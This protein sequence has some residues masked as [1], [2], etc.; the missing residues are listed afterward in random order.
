MVGVNSGDGRGNLTAYATVF[1]SEAGPAARPRLLGLLAECE[2]RS[3]PSAAAVRRPTRAGSSRTSRPTTSRWIPPIRSA[4][5]TAQQSV[6]TDL[7]NFGP[8]NHYQ[9][10]ERRYSI[11]AMGHYEFGEHADVY[12]QLM[13]NDYESIAQ[14]APG[15]N[16]FN[17]S[18]HQLRQP[19]PAGQQPGDI[20]CTPGG[21]RGGRL[22]D[23]V[24]RP[25]QRR[26]RR[27]PAVVREQL[28]PRRRGRAWRDQRRL[29]LRRRRRS[30][31]ASSVE[32][33][34]ARTTSS[35][36][37]SAG[38]GRGRRR[39]RADLPSVIDGT[40]PNC[41]PWNPFQPNGVD[42]DQLELP[43]GA[44]ACRSAASTRRSTTA[45]STATSASTASSRRSPPTASRSCSAPSGAATRSTNTVDS[46]QAQ[47]QLSG[48]GGAV[49]GISGGTKVEELFIEGT[50]SD[51][52]GPGRAWRASRSTPRTG[53]RTTATACRP[54]PTSSASSGRRSQDVRL[55]GS[56]QH[57][58]RAANIVELFTAQGTQPVRRAGR[59]LRRGGPRPGGERRGV[60]RDRRARRASSAQPRSTARRRSTPS[61]RAAIPDLTPE[62]SDTYSYGVVFTPR[63]APG[64]AITVDYFDIKIDDTISTFGGQQH[65]DG[66]LREQRPGGLRAHP[67]QPGT[68][69]LW[70]NGSGFVEDLNVNI[71]SI[72]DDRATTSTSATRGS[73]SAASAASRST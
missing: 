7:Y 49:I 30:T 21:S 53:T 70:T 69:Q 43:A 24:H 56:Y 45:S 2:S 1:D 71:G 29:G 39:R 10:P 57:A 67:P 64:L 6:D 40:D 20:G 35:R 26:G 18:S 14:I 9:R 22:G 68:G 48:A 60:H 11:G 65:L 13:F 25:A 15:G 42:A 3:A 41:V 12:T 16:F 54:T 8:L 59:S 37:A 44:T 32:H 5:R 28:V 58:V 47:D 63:F 55:R 31:R 19:V 27:T 38:A 72:V 4:R 33:G 61:C 23:D 46:L 66:L 51:R 36:A 52:A 17:S 62:E 73:K 50:H 34:D